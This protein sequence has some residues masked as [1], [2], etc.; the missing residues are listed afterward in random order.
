MSQ[1]A[2]LLGKTDDAARYSSVADAVRTSY[3]R[4]L[5]HRDTNQYG[6]GSQT[7]N[8]ISLAVGLVPEE[9]RQAVVDNLVADV[10]SHQNHVTAGDIGFHYVLES[11]NEGG[12]SDVIC[13]MLSRNDPPSY[14]YQLKMGA[15]ALTE[16]WNS[17]PTSSQNHFMLGHAEEWFYRGLAGL[18]FDL[19]RSEDEQLVLRPEMVCGI[20]SASASYDSVKGRISISWRRSGKSTEID[21]VV[22]PG[23]TALV[24]VP[25]ARKEDVRESGNPVTTAKGVSWLRSCGG[26][27]MIRIASGAYHFVSNASPASAAGAAVPIQH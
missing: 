20:A 7:A 12:R 19:S 15:T 8:A 10:R 22:P 3:N 26:Y 18:D 13:D 1:I 6:T 25:G 5:L 14:G 17:D 9:R 23:M 27:Q 11:L 21:A 2:V 24:R 4:E 16:A